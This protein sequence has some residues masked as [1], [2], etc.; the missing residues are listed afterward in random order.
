MQVS[1]QRAKVLNKTATSKKR[2]REKKGAAL[3]MRNALYFVA[4]TTI[5]YSHTTLRA[6]FGGMLLLL[7]LLFSTGASAAAT[8]AW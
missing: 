4:M 5:P 2:S 6:L 8:A 1:L 3:I 7:T